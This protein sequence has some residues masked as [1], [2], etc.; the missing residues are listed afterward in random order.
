MSEILP[1]LSQHRAVAVATAIAAGVLLVVV[2][3]SPAH[4]SVVPAV[5]LGTAGSYELLAGS[6]ITNTGATVVTNGDVGLSPGT[7]VTGFPPGVITNGVIHAADAQAQQA[8]TDLVTAYNDA[9]GRLPDAPIV[10]DTLGGLTLGPGVYNGGALDLTGT[11]TLRGDANSVWIFQAASTLV[12]ASNSVVAFQAAGASG[13]PGPCNVFWQ[14]GSSATIGTGSQFGGTVIALSSITANA[15][16]V[17]D[18]RLLARNQA[19]TLISDAVTRPADCAARSAIVASSPT[20][21][22]TA[23]AAAAAAQ[24]AAAA[25]QAA[26]ATP[27]LPATGVDPLP[28]LAASAALFLAGG[29]VLIASWIRRRP[30]ERNRA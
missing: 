9:A 6:T 14:V 16:A 21:A 10:G 27:R 11:I 8:Q 2:S 28:G 7:A 26:A 15:G 20:A 1:R 19:V 25:A 18:G 3:G 23:A 12:T 5:G 17:V 24:A 30:G 22:Q 4:A 13:T 29:A